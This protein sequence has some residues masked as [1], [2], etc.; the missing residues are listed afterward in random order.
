[1]NFYVVIE[2]D[3]GKIR[4]LDSEW[5]REEIEQINLWDVLAHCDSKEE[6]KVKRLEL[7]NDES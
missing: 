3:S 6:A 5:P 2:S 1:M 4:T 7:I